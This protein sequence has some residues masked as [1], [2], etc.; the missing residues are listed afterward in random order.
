MMMKERGITKTPGCSWLHV[1]NR[2]HTFVGDKSNME[3][4]KIYHF[5]DELVEKEKTENLCNHSEKLAV[6]FGILNLNGQSTM[7]DSLRFY[8]FKNGSCSCKDLW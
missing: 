1:G 4:D 3:S 6:A 8:H 7:R 2:V 5:L